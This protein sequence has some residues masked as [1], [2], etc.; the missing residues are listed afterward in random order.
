DVNEGIFETPEGAAPAPVVVTDQGPLSSNQMFAIGIA[1]QSWMTGFLVG[2]ISSGSFG[3]G[4]KHGIILLG[5]SMIA[6]VMTQ[7]FNL[8]PSMFLNSSGPPA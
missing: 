3:T 6:T 7:E 1:A 4:F 8:S 5:I 2:K